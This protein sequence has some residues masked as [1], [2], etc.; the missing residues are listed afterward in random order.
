MSYTSQKTT[1]I[2]NPISGDYRID[3]LLDSADF[4]WNYGAA[5]GTTANVT[6]SFMSVA[7]AYADS[8]DA[9]GFFAFNDAQKTAVRSILT[10]ISEYFNINFTEVSDSASSYG[11]IRFGNNSQGNVSSGYAYMPDPADGELGGD[12]FING[13]DET[14]L[15]QIE[16]GTDAWDT[17]VHEIGH[18]LGLKHPGDYNAGEQASGEAGNYLAA[19]E[20]TERNTVMSYNSVSHML[21]E[22]YGKYDF[23]ALDYLYGMRSVNTGD[24][25]YAYDDEAGLMLRTIYDSG[26]E[27]TID[28]SATTTSNTIDLRAGADSSIGRL[29]N[30]KAAS[31]DICIAYDVTIENAIGGGASDTLIGNDADNTLD[32]G[33]GKDKMRGG[34]GDD[35]YYVDNKGDVVT[36]A[37]NEGTDT[38]VCSLSYTLVNNVEYMV[39]AGSDNLAATGNKGDNQLQGNAGANILT[40]KE[41]NDT[42]EGGAGTDRFVF[43]T[44][45]DAKANLDIVSDFVSGVDVLA[46]S[47]K[48]FTV[49][50]KAAALGETD[51]AIFNSHGIV[52]ES[53]ESAASTS[54]TH[55]LYDIGSG[56]LYYDS[57]GNGDK[58]AVQFATL[59]GTPDIVASDFY[60][61]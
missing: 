31:K 46:L 57:D 52:P 14:N 15:E 29:D 34:V 8:E 17:L 41:G 43:D 18:T 36:E 33:T 22:F 4:R 37:A 12:L 48:I 6:Y 47:K 59:T 32:G 44:K 3:V 10:Q 25:T 50:K 56:A 19:S 7:P 40:G 26:G 53:V 16:P 61:I 42:L 58:V 2:A 5:L 20:D 55:V 51:F 21:R 35:T 54:S 11:Q 28:A 27:D 39:L 9:V 45:L 30:N 60:V 38:M 23:L 1:V 49:Y 24:S 13:D